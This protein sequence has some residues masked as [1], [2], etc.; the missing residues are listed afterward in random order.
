MWLLNQFAFKLILLIKLVIC[1]NIFFL[2][3]R[4]IIA[5][6]KIFQ[7]TLFRD[8]IK[9][10]QIEL[11]L[12]RHCWT[13]VC[14]KKVS[15]V[16]RETH[17]RTTPINFPVVFASNLAVKKVN[18]VLWNIS[19]YLSVAS[20]AVVATVW[21]QMYNSTKIAYYIFYKYNIIWLLEEML[22]TRKLNNNWKY[23]WVCKL[24]HISF[25]NIPL[26]TD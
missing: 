4:V 5:E 22:V 1:V 14:F 26:C 13:V 19:C 2:L 7:E 9:K 6:M 8:V 21:L 17:R 12:F 20:V 16:T 25:C 3:N 11:K 15:N 23:F 24:P 10:K 18:S